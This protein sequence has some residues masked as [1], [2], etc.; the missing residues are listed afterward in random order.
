MRLIDL[1]ATIKEV[2]NSSPTIYE[3]MYE[4]YQYSTNRKVA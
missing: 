2:G 4:T 1:F 3:I